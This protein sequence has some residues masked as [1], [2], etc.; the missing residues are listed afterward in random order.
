MLGVVERHVVH[1]EDVGFEVALLVGGVWAVDAAKGLYST[2]YD[3]V[4]LDVVLAV[5]AFKA[6][7]TDRTIRDLCAGVSGR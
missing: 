6:L 7:T 2:V 3:H 5:D 4:F 1:G